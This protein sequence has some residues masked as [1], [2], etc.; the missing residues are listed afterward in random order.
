M[1]NAELEARRSVPVSAARLL[2]CDSTSVPMESSMSSPENEKLNADI[3]GCGV[4]E[5]KRVR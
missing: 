1:G 3:L 2:G 5:S 4:D